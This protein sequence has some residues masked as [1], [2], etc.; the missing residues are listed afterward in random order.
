MKN[1]KKIVRLAYLH[2]QCRLGINI[3]KWYVLYLIPEPTTMLLLG[4]GLVGLAGL[5]RKKF[6]K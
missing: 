2:F 4:F 6:K 1:T 5:G 3:I